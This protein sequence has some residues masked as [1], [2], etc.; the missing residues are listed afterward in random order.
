MRHTEVIIFISAI[1]ISLL[2]GLSSLLPVEIYSSA[3]W[4]ILWI[5][6]A[7]ALIFSIIIIVRQ[8]YNNER[9]TY[10]GRLRR[11]GPAFIMHISFLLMIAGGF[12]TSLFSRR[13]TLHLFPSQ[14]ADCFISSDGKIKK[15]PSAVTLL[16][17]ATE[18]YPGKNLHKDFKSELKTATGDTMRI[19]MNHIGRLEDYR[20][21][22]TSYDDYGGTFL[23]VTY[24]PTGT[25]LV[26]TGFI[27]FIS[28]GVI[29]I[30]RNIRRHSARLTNLYA[31]A[32]CIISLG[33][34]LISLSPAREGVIPILAT[35]WMPVHVGFCCAGY[36]VLGSTLPIAVI[37]LSRHRLSCRQHFANIGIHLILPGVFLLG[38]GIITGAMWAN[39]SWGR[40][41]AWDPKETWSLATLLLYSIPLHRYFKMRRQPK[42]FSIYLILAFSS[43]IMT[44]FGVNFLPSLHAY[45]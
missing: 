1:V 42:F 4:H 11:N 44:Y 18:Y 34:C 25:A 40:Y 17:F 28:T 32:V 36:A 38:L 20:F 41:W 35:Y 5:A 21:Y 30:G 12:C 37:A 23:T 24:D 19:S 33:A 13:G 29:E 26:Y 16:S 2:I 8:T 9:T 31:I 22:Q 27:L 7:V 43:I 14:T 10:M 3:I 6:I 15:L 39:V 45:N